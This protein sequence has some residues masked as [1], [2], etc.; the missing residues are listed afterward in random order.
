MADLSLG[1]IGLAD[2]PTLTHS[3]SLGLTLHMPDSDVS[4]TGKIVWTSGESK[5]NRAG[6]A[7]TNVSSVDA[8]L[9]SR[10]TERAPRQLPPAAALS[11]T[12]LE[13]LRQTSLSF[14]TEFDRTTLL[15]RIV[16]QAVRLLGA[17]S[18]G[19][20]EV[21][22][23]MVLSPRHRRLQSPRPLRQDPEARRGHGRP[24]GVLRRSFH[25]RERL[26]RLAR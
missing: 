22:S 9:L 12:Q 25:D 21:Q 10:W 6:I 19:I 5:G 18:G 11:A 16:E 3:D 4:L 13:L 26:Q 17:Q 24:A 20:Y 2:T 15:R 1:G 14:A 23:P 8:Q 7:F